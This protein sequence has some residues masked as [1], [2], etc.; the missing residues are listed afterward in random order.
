L[1]TRR[2]NLLRVCLHHSDMPEPSFRITSSFCPGAWP[3]PHCAVVSNAG[4]CHRL[5]DSR[6]LASLYPVPAWAQPALWPNAGCLFLTR[7]T[8]RISLFRVPVSPGCHARESGVCSI[9]KRLVRSHF[10]FFRPRAWPRPHCAA[11]S[12][13]GISNRLLGTRRLA[14]THSP[15]LLRG[16]RPREYSHHADR[17]WRRY[18]S[19]T[20]ACFTPSRGD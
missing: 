6:R 18:L 16:K 13:A 19:A 14:T 1:L 8:R 11:V 2:F 5:L 10:S 3:R 7:S 17:Q 12:N 15:C 9:S 20:P 4:I